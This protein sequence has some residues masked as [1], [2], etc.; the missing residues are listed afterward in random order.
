MSP[1]LHARL[2]GEFFLSCDDALTGVITS[3]SR[4][5]L[6]YLLLY[7]QTPQPRQRIAVHLWPDSTDSQA[8]TNLRK[9]LSQLRRVL[10][11]ADRFL[12][13][14]TKT[15]AWQPD[16]QFALDV[17]Q[18]E[19]AI[20]TAALDSSLTQSMLEKAA[21]LYRGDLLLDC[22]DEWIVSERDRLRQKHIRVLEQ[23]IALLEV[24]FLHKHFYQ[25]QLLLKN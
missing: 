8:R 25:I 14:D 15:L 11:N 6:A 2:L 20:K 4:A 12:L 24:Y 22:D 13:I 19:D 10:P 18:F 23:L 9:E 17:A 1:V 16:V 3:R 7:R 21:E 5:L